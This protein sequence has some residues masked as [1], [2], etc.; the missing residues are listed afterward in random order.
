[1]SIQNFLISRFL[2]SRLKISLKTHAEIRLHKGRKFLDQDRSK[3]NPRVAVRADV[4]AGVKMEWVEPLELVGDKA[5]PVCMYTH[6]GGYIAGGLNSHRDMAR[7]LALLAHVRMLMVDYRLAPEH[8]F[9]AA[10]DDAFAVYRALLDSGIAGKQILLGGDSAGGNLALLTAQ[11][12]RDAGLASP[13]AMVLFSPWLDMTH[14]SA[15]YQSNATKDAML[16]R[17]LLDDAA[18]M[19]APGMARTDARISPLFGNLEG[20]PPCLTVVSQTEVLLD[21]SRNLHHKLQALGA[22]STCLEWKSTPH[23]FAVM[24]SLLPEARDALRQTADF[25]ARVR[26]S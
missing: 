4:M 13:F 5:A 20:L 14:Q 19:Y 22:D 23:A 12:I 2:K 21:D 26:R 3:P 1:M 11:G 8:P 16:A 25:I 17:P 15:T 9:P 6:G 18:A 24:P 7:H 10:R